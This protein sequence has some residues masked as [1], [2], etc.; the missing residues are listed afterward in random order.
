MVD[1]R[2]CRCGGQY[3]STLTIEA[4]IFDKPVI[5]MWYFAECARALRQ[6]IYYPYPLT[7]HI[8]HVLKA[9]VAALATSRKELITAIYDAMADPDRRQVQR[10]ELVKR[11]CGKLDGKAISRLIDCCLKEK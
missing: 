1:P 11:E 4:C 8:G 5:N 10:A 3:F 2:L 7:D 6:P 9:G